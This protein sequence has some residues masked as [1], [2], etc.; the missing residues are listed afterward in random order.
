MKAYEPAM[1]FDAASAR[2]HDERGDESA[3]VSF[4]KDLAGA[5]PVLELA[6]GTGRLALPLVAHGVPVDGIDIAPAMVERLQAKPGGEQIAVVL[7]DFADVPVSGAYPLIFVAWNSFF[8]LPTQQDQL[9]CFTN[10]AEHLTDGGVFAIEVFTPNFLFELSGNQQLATES[11]EV[12]EV[13]ISAMRHEPATQTLEQSHVSLS[14]SGVR[15][16]PV[17]QRYAWPSELDLMARL[18]G[19]RLRNRYGGWEK[20]EFDSTS[21][22]H[23]SVYGR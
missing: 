15:M 20:S 4:L 8:N 17:V 22:L 19:L 1:S 7:G 23:V 5:G 18:A 21:A 12:D 10:V 3:A 11:V 9:R 6:I 13:R 2:L 14:P 16:T